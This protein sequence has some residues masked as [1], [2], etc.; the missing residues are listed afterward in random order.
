[1]DVQRGNGSRV[2]LWGEGEGCTGRGGV[3]GEVMQ[4]ACKQNTPIV[5]NHKKS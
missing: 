2:Q 5:N 3:M 1:M 4:Q